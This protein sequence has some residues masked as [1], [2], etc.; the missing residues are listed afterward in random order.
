M[1]ANLHKQLSTYPAIAVAPVIPWVLEGRQ[2]PTAVAGYVA[3]V[4]I[5]NE[6]ADEVREAGTEPVRV[7]AGSGGRKQV[8][9]ELLK[10]IAKSLS[11]N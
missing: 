3:C 10:Y 9:L 4:D 6:A 1:A 11:C 2:I 7:L 5:W 8:T